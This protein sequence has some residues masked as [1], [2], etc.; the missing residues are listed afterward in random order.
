VTLLALG[1]MVAANLRLR[2]GWALGLS[3]GLGALHG[4]QN[5]AAMAQSRLGLTGLSGVVATVFV[6]I[7]LTSAL[8]VA[9]RAPWAR[10][11]VRVGGSWVAAA[12]LLMLGWSMRAA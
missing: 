1:A 6:V 12:G 3:I 8:V 9:L 11:A 4:Y 7:A 2:A 5:G 10:M